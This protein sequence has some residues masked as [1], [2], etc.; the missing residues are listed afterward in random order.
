MSSGKRVAIIA[1]GVIGVIV[2]VIVAESI[3]SR[4]SVPEGEKPWMN[5]VDKQLGLDKKKEYYDKDGKDDYFDEDNAEEYIKKMV[6][7]G[8]ISAEQAEA[9]MEYFRQ[10]KAD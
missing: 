4:P 2:V 3:M 5:A 9:K 7:E 10:E 1:L 6:E 8:K